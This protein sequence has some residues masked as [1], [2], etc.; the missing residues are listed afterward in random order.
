[1]AFFIRFLRWYPD[2]KTLILMKTKNLEAINLMVAMEGTS[3]SYWYNAGIWHAQCV[4]LCSG[5][6]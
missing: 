4:L 5:P 1:M 3:N 6:I 2:A